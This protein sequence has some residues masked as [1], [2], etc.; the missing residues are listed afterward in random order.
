MI[1]KEKV[2]QLI[3]SIKK[4]T[5]KTQKEIAVGAGYKENT[6]TQLLSKGENLD[7]VYDQLMRVYRLNNSTPNLDQIAKTLERIENGQ[8]YIR[9][10]I[11]GYGQYQIMEKAGWDQTKF[12]KAMDKVGKLIGAN[13][14]AGDLLG[15]DL[16]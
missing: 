9:A 11:R 3:N 13:L 8:A 7:A 16:D 5:G 15:S 1:S 2:K 14:S 6:L 12:L 10:E 4:E